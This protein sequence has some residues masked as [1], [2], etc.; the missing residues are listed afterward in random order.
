MATRGERAS[1]A[2]RLSTAA[3][4]G[5][6][7]TVPAT[8]AE[9]PPAWLGVAA[10]SG[11]FGLGLVGLTWADC[12]GPDGGVRLRGRQRNTASR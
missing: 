2:S 8:G 3:A 4:A 12:C 6:D 10:G 9:G 5:E 1:A 7:G 11:A